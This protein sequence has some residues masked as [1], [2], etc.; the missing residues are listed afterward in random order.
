MATAA[1]GTPW[2]AAA[3]AA[4]AAAGAA[5]AAAEADVHHH[6]H[7]HHHHPCFDVWSYHAA[8]VP[9]TRSLTTDQ[10]EMTAHAVARIFSPNASLQ[11]LRP[12]AAYTD[13]TD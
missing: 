3:A 1:G 8:R 7:H 5:A 4:A 10:R 9:A 2:A 13:H 12:C 6:H 11:L